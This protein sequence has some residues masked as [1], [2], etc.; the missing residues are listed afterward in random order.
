MGGTA[1]LTVQPPLALPAPAP[2][3]QFSHPVPSPQRKAPEEPYTLS[4]GTAV[5]IAT[6][7]HAEHPTQRGSAAAAAAL[8]AADVLLVR[9][10][11]VTGCC[12]ARGL[13]Y[14]HEH[15]RC[16]TALCFRLGSSRPDIC[17]LDTVIQGSHIAML[18]IRVRFVQG[19]NPFEGVPANG[20]RGVARPGTVSGKDHGEQQAQR[21]ESGAAG[22]QVGISA[23]QTH[24]I[25]GAAVATVICAPAYAHARELPVLQLCCQPATMHVPLSCFTH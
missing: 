24:H 11:L 9:Y 17:C 3:P 16:D 18:M 4:P 13:V 6:A 21:T 20:M 22:H 14:S 1:G 8:P 10:H 19:P 25:A 12:T 23:G 7:Q 15:G 2:E 5:A